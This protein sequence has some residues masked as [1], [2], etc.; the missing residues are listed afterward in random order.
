M[1]SSPPCAFRQRW[2]RNNWHTPVLG[3]FYLRA[4]Y[5]RMK[6]VIFDVEGTLVDCVGQTLECWHETLA[7]FG[8]QF[9]VERLHGFSGM[10]G[11]AMLSALLPE[12]VREKLKQPIL[13]A[14]GERYRS[15]FLPTVRPLPGVRTLFENLRGR[16]LKIAL[17]TTCDAT[18]LKHYKSILN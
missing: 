5:P 12:D 6:A 2:P 14:Q 3:T 1:A 8:F 10:D 7:E 15:K 17:A 9:T 13:N 11:Q 4:P 16:G 18:E